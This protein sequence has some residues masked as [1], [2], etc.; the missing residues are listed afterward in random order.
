MGWRDFW[1]H[2][3]ITFLLGMLLMAGIWAIGGCA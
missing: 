3:V 1:T 2:P